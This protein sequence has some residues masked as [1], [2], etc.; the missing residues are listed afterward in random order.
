MERS[1]I[2]RT[3]VIQ[4]ILDERRTAL[5]LPVKPQPEMALAYCSMGYNSGSWGYSPFDE[6]NFRKY[7]DS[8]KHWKPPC[9][10]DDTLVVKEAWRVRKVGGD[11][12]QGTR[13][14][15]IEFRAGGDTAV[16]TVLNAKFDMF[17]TG[18]KWNPPTTMPK[19]AARIFLKAESISVQRLQDISE[20]GAQAEGIYQLANGKDAGCWTY[21]RNP[22]EKKTYGEIWSKDEGAKYCYRWVWDAFI[23]P[24]DRTLFGWDANPWTWL[25]QFQ[26]KKGA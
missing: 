19:E 10:I 25:I 9:H 26:Q 3:D 4:S 24:A 18:V 8:M 15:E 23:K 5:R 6:E 21:R 7:R 13:W 12:R 11:Y 1:I 22:Y 2:L 14:A 17:R 16:I 20:A